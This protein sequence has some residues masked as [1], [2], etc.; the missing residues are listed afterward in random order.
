MEEHKKQWIEQVANILLVIREKY[1]Y[2]KYC[3][4]EVSTDDKFFDDSCNFVGLSHEIYELEQTLR[5][6]LKY[7]DWSKGVDK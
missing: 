4:S 2:S 3:C 5:R 6:M 7:S 1:P